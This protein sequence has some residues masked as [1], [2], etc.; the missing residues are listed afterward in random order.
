MSAMSGE[1]VDTSTAPKTPLVRA[2][3]MVYAITGWSPSRRMF[4]FL[5]RFEPARAGISPMM[6]GGSA[7]TMGLPGSEATVDRQV[8]AGHVPR[9]LGGEEDQRPR[10]VGGFRHAA[11][12]HP[13]RVL[14]LEL[15][16]LSSDYPSRRQR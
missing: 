9:C 15:V 12:R 13:G 16:V 10:E 2:T 11:H 4:L 14:A 7:A 5:T 8:D 3:A 1:S 6:L